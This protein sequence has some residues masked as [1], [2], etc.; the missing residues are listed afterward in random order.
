MFNKTEKSLIDLLGKEY[1]AAVKSCAVTLNGL[2][3]QEA[4]RLLQERIPFFPEKKAEHLD[5]LLQKVGQQVVPPFINDNKGAATQSF[6]RASHLNAAPIN[7]IGPFRVGEDGR[8]YYAAKSEHYHASLGHLFAGYQLVEHAKKLGIPNATHNN[9]RGFIT[10]YLERELI[11][12]VN[13]LD[14]DDDVELESILVSKEPHVLNRIINLE[15]GSLAVEAGVKMMLRRFY[16]LEVGENQPE[17]DGKIPVFLVI[18][19]LTDGPEANY[20]GTTIVT[21]TMRG[22]WPNLLKQA[23]AQGIYRVVSV[24]QNDIADFRD[25]INQFNQ[26][27]YRTAGFLH[28]IILMN[29]GGIQLDNA[30]LQAAYNLCRQYQTPVLVDEIQSCM[31]YSGM[32]LFRH[33]HLQPDFV[34]LGKGFSGGE[35]PASKVITTYEMDS[36]T[37]FGALVTNGQEELASLAYLVTMSF[38]INHAADIDQI[39]LYIEKRLNELRNLHPVLIDKIEGKGHLAAIHF[40]SLNLAARF[41]SLMNNRCIDVSAQTYK[42]N[43]PPAVL[44]KLPMI[45]SIKAIDYLAEQMADVMNQLAHD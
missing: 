26:G 24:R 12:H 1:A 22:L 25:K 20:H 38:V 6:A 19:D 34:I 33:Y 39:G 21:Q 31:W 42:T 37:Q 17:H 28:E 9:T 30:Y 8:L 32:F 27:Q 10:R 40:K 4:D 35:Y 18:A 14:L 41:A 3:E 15:T 5:S 11:R 2:D 23:E 16:K 44:L 36:M 29:Y 7:G 13:G 45:A 43:C